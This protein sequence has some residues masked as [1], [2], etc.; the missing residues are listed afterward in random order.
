MSRLFLLCLVFALPGCF[1]EVNSLFHY[2]YPIQSDGTVD[3][4][5][6]PLED[7]QNFTITGFYPPELGIH[8]VGIYC[9]GGQDLVV[10]GSPWKALIAENKS[11]NT[12]VVFNIGVDLANPDLPGGCHTSSV[13]NGQAVKDDILI[14][15]IQIG[16]N[17]APILS[18]ENIECIKDKIY[19][20]GKHYL[21]A[22][23]EC[24]ALDSR[25]ST[26]PLG[27]NPAGVIPQ[28]IN[29]LRILLPASK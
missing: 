4:R 21:L 5:L 23:K 22:T 15:A 13:V 1:Y 28:G 27:L 25:G 16:D 18:D 9:P 2:K 3:L 26:N 17:L 24:I 20:E 6:A 7:I 10:F 11:A 8:D 29:R 19:S 14:M 12:E